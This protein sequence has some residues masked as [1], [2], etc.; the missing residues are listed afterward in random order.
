MTRRAP[1]A[2]HRQ[3]K[4]QPLDWVGVPQGPGSDVL[5]L[6][7]DWADPCGDL[8]T[9]EGV[10]HVGELYAPLCAGPRVPGGLSPWE[11]KTEPWDACLVCMTI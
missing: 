5:S 11:F 7:V 6:V 10:D 8:Q 3:C 4:T 9:V 1:H 2:I